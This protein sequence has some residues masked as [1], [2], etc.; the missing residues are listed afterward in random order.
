MLQDVL[1][2][3]QEQGGLGHKYEAACC[4]N[5]ALAYRRAGDDVKA[6]LQL[7]R[8]IDSFPASVYSQAAERLLKQRP[9]RDASSDTPDKDT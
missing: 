2:S 6:V 4:Y 9:E 8:V 3:V 1:T 7:N 5:L